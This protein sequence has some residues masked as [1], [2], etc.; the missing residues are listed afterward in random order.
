MTVEFQMVPGDRPRPGTEAI[1]G[2]VDQVCFTG[3]RTRHRR[4]K[5]VTRRKPQI[6]PAGPTGPSAPR[7]LAPAM[8]PRSG[9]RSIGKSP[10]VTLSGPDDFGRFTGR[11][12]DVADRQDAG[13]SIGTSPPGVRMRSL[14]ESTR[15]RTDELSCPPGLP[16]G[17]PSKRRTRSIWNVPCERTARAG[18]RILRRR[19]GAVEGERD[20]HT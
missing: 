2:A 9:R 4:N 14:A 8:Q 6:G 13:S 5:R 3:T 20:E 11:G 15:N 18:G 10:G 19:F 17:L 1:V 16:P 7:K 12:Q